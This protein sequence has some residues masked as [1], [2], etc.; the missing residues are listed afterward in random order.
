MVIVYL[1]LVELA[2]TP[3]YRAPHARAP[4]ARTP[5]PATSHAQRLEQR[6][7]RR[8]SRYIHHPAQHPKTAAQPEDAG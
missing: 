1:L 5:R 8:A 6:I 7:R 4:H 2:K 3:F